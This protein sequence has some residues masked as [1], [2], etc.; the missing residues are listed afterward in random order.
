[1]QYVCIH[2]INLKIPIKCKL[3]FQVDILKYNPSII[4]VIMI[5]SDWIPLVIK[6]RNKG[7]IVVCL[8]IYLIVVGCCCCCD[9]SRWYPCRPSDNECLSVIIIYKYPQW[10]PETK[11]CIVVAVSKGILYI[12][13]NVSIQQSSVRRQA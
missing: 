6:T 1:M 3:R 2:V 13:I 5:Y 10:L 4:T 8:G 7:V 12:C 9:C 11:L